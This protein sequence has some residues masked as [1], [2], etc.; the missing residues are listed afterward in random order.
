[1]LFEIVGVDVD[2]PWDKEIA[3][4]IGGG[5]DAATSC[6]HAGYGIADDMHSAE[7]HGVPNDDPGVGEDCLSR[8]RGLFDGRS[9]P[10]D[11][12]RHGTRRVP[13]ARGPRSALPQSGR[14]QYARTLLRRSGIWL[15]GCPVHHSPSTIVQGFSLEVEDQPQLLARSSAECYGITT[16]GA[17]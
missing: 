9:P 11:S 15:H 14:V 10:G 4:E 5:R 16:H 8:R 17:A 12:S 3:I 13:R 7:K 6:A 1:M 2:E